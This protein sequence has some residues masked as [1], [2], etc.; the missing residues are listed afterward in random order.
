MKTVAFHNLGCKVNDYET[1]IM[2]QLFTENGFR[3]VGFNE[4]ADVYVVNTCT[5]TN[6]ADR[7]SRQML[8]RAKKLNPDAVV[9]AVGCYVQTAGEKVL[10]DESIDIAIGNNKKSEIINI[11]NEY[12]KDNGPDPHAGIIDI[13]KT[14]EYESMFLTDTAERTR[15]YIKIQDGCDQFC[16]Y[17][18]IP[19]ARGRARSRNEADILEEVKGLAAKGYREFV[20]TGIHVSSYGVDRIVN[21]GKKA[22]FNT[23]GREWTNEYLIG[24]LKAME[25]IDGVE[26]IRLSSLEP[27]IVTEEFARRISEIPKLCPHFHLSLQS[28]S[29]ETLKRMNRHY[30]ADEYLRGVELLRKYFD[31]PAITT[32]IIVGFPG[33][34]DRDFKESFEFA[35]KVSF[36]EMHIFKYSKRNGTAAAKMPDQVADGVKEERSHIM[37]G[38]RDE[39]SRE[40]RRSYIG[41]VRPVLFEEELKVGRETFMVGFTPEYIKVATPLRD[42]TKNGIYDVA[43]EDFLDDEVMKGTVV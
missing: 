17:C 34:S 10:K 2:Q 3:V 9:I 18:L 11:L 5:V 21:D 40:F 12:L 8:H 1:D 29:N 24:L 43:I 14:S 31:D 33:E 22:E 6:I 30:T 7:K 26:R 4:K 41:K 35:R 15:A 23:M 36:Y 27:R 16:S 32:D 37:I 28:G 19:Y 13:N 39:L 42:V 38:L 20:L 25:S